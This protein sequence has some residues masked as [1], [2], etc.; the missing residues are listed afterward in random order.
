ML[1]E[2]NDP[3][4]STLLVTSTQP[5]EGKSTVSLNLAMSLAALGRRVLLV[6]ADT[7][8]PSVHTVLGLDGEPGLT[9]ILAGGVSWQGVLQRDVTAG[10]D[11]L[12]AGGPAQSPAD[13]LSSRAM[14]S[15]LDAAQS[16]Y[17]FVILDSPAFLINAADARILASLV[18]AVI[19]VV[20]SG[21]TS[22]DHVRAVVR[23]TPNVMGVVLND[24][25]MREFASYYGVDRTSGSS[26]EASDAVSPTVRGAGPEGAHTVRR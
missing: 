16:V 20:R 11:V 6:D 19:L 22:R 17:D 13:L 25:G 23:Q 5:G 7:R 21:A 9:E 18:D 12:P 15:I 4:P 24:L 3:P 26:K 10:L 8:R 2:L 14:K 1:F